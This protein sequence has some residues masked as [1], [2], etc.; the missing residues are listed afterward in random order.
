MDWER[1]HE[2]NMRIVG[3]SLG[4]RHTFIHRRRHRL[5]VNSAVPATLAVKVAALAGVS[6]LTLY[7]SSTLAL[8]GDVFS[9][10]VIT[11]AGNDYTLSADA[12]AAS[13]A[14][15]VA[16][17]PVLAADVSTDDI[18]TVAPNVVLTDRLDG[19][20]L[21]GLKEELD[22]VRVEFYSSQAFTWRI[23]V[24]SAPLTPRAGHLIDIPELGFEGQV[25]EIFDQTAGVYPTA[26]DAA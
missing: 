13:S 25:K 11:I 19:E 17:I 9:G 1:Q 26:V 7:A 12:S 22:L 21:W 16:F 2:R 18:V 20:K 8:E 24:N 6:A 3:D 23:P 10:L 5:K 15:V 14:L 4:S